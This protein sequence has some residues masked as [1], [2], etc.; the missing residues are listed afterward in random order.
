MTHKN[1]VGQFV[2]FSLKVVTCD[3]N[4]KTG[5]QIKHYTNVTLPKIDRHNVAVMAAAKGGGSAKNPNHLKNATLNLLL[6]SGSVRTVH[7]QLIVEFNG[8]PVL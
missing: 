7:T 2:P 8:E 5:G 3:R 6:P 4:K 1:E